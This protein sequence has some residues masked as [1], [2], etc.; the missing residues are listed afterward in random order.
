MGLGY[1]DLSSVV[2]SADFLLASGA[3]VPGAL[4]HRVAVAVAVPAFGNCRGRSAG[5]GEG[6]HLSAR[7]NSAWPTPRLVIN[8]CRRFHFRASGLCSKAALGI[9]LASPVEIR[10]FFEV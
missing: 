10:D 3:D 5:A 1:A 7:A 8:L 6:D 4:S 2:H 9:R